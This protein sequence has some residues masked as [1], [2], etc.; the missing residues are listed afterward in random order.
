MARCTRCGYWIETPET[1][2]KLPLCLCDLPGFDQVLRSL[3]FE[4]VNAQQRHADEEQ[5]REMEDA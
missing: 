5:A 1:R 2:G 3:G 4:T